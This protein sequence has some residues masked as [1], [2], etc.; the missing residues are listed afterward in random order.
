M[1]SVS[2]VVRTHVKGENMT[3]FEAVLPFAQAAASIVTAVIAIVVYRVTKDIAKTD[4][5]REINRLWQSFN[6]LML[7]QDNA[8]ALAAFLAE[9]D[10][11]DPP[12]VSR[13]NY[14]LFSFLNCMHLE[15]I[16]YK[17]NFM[18]RT[19]HKKSLKDHAIFLSPRRDYVVKL[20]QAQGFD[21]RFVNY[22]KA[23][24]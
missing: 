10:R 5:N 24:L 21:P 8:D 13:I 3:V 7:Q 12:P 16:S 2:Y 15:F 11:G 6:E 18:S 14:I 22:M 17:K 23:R 9:A 19:H 20:M 1:D 4:A